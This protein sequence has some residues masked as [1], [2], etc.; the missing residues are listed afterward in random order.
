MCIIKPIQPLSV[1]YCQIIKSQNHNKFFMKKFI[2]Q[3]LF[4]IIF[5][6]TLLAQKEAN[7]WY[8]GGYAGLNFNNGSPVP[9]LDGALFQHEGCATISDSTGKLLFYT[10]GIELWNKN[11]QE[12]DNGF[13][14]LGGQSA[15]Q[16][17]IIVPQ[18]ESD[19]LFY[20]FTVPEEIGYDGLRY[21]IVDI[22][23]NGGLGSVIS[24]NIFL[25]S[26]TEEK[27]TAVKHYNNRDIWV[28]THLWDSEAFYVYLVTPE[29]LNPSPKIFKVGSY[30]NGPDV[31]GSMK[32]S[33]DGR[34]LAIIY[35]TLQTVELFD[36]N[37][38]TGEISNYLPFNPQFKRGYGIEFSQDASLMYIG[39]YYNRSTI[40]QFDLNAGTSS[41]IIQSGIEIG[42]VSN[43]HLGA[44]QM[45]PDGKIY[46][47]KHND[48]DG[49]TFLGVIN[50]PD[51]RG[52][53]CDFI[54]D[55]LYLGG[56]VCF[57]GLPTFIQSYF[58]QGQ[59]ILS[60]NTC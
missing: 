46:V 15:T 47:A 19:N 4:F 2:L 17:G 8:F 54:E 18:P 22:S 48:L 3:L 53:A 14:L 12:M 60:E 56:R 30:H 25:V 34:K 35:R 7:I 52:T 10:N 31:H 32:A 21:S 16:S 40:T 24:K 5:S 43:I 11:H 49:D 58:Y 1:L 44:L 29:G 42:S 28:I 50:K 37:N 27:V 39:N 59:T 6:N 26:P 33:P 13:G 45:G 55:G 20:V 38:K 57:W 36:F 41:D 51:E 23:K 9:L